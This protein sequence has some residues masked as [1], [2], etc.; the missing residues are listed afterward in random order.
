MDGKGQAL[1]NAITERFFLTIE[2]GLIY[3]DEFET[4]RDLRKAINGYIVEYNTYRLHFSIGGFWPVEV[5]NFYL[6]DVA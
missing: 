6:G 1:D 4:P 2:Y 5:Y 3:I